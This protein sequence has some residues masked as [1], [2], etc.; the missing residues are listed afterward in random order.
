[1]PTYFAHLATITIRLPLDID[2]EAELRALRQAGIPVNAQG[3]VEAG[4]LFQRD[5]RGQK[6]F[7]VFRWFAGDVDSRPVQLR[8]RQAH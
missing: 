6:R 2:R 3:Q 4:Y 8:E 7:T 5:G 1:M